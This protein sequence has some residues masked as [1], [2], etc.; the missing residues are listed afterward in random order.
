VA[1]IDLGPLSF[2]DTVQLLQALGPESPA[3]E[4][5]AFARWIFT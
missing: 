5:E 1:Q 4:S 3:P 2:E